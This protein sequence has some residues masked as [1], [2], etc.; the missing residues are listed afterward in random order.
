MFEVSI[1]C[2]LEKITKILN[3]I[4]TMPNYFCY[5]NFSDTSMAGFNVLSM[6][7]EVKPEIASAENN[8]DRARRDMF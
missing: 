5:L 6:V 3:I 4:R 7:D 8:L 1:K 2:E